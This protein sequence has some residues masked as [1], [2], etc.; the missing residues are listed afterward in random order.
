M[1]LNGAG[2]LSEG[3][4]LEG[5]WIG[6]HWIG[7]LDWIGEAPKGFYPSLSTPNSQGD[8]DGEAP[9]GFYPSLS[10]PPKSPKSPNLHVF[11]EPGAFT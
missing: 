7:A 9:K 10:T 6:W 8:W 2:L 5:C 4:G 1:A 3:A 11:V